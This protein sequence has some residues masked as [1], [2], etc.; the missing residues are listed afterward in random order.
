MV[1]SH[2]P[3]TVETW[4]ATQA[5]ALTGNRTGNPLIHRLALIPLNRTSQ[6]SSGVFELSISLKHLALQFKS[7]TTF[8]AF[9][10]VLFPC[11]LSSNYCSSENSTFPRGERNSSSCLGAFCHADPSVF[12]CLPCLRKAGA[13]VFF[14]FIP[15]MCHCTQCNAGHGSPRVNSQSHLNQIFECGPCIT[16]K[17]LVSVNDFISLTHSKYST[18]SPY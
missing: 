7:Q 12:L 11:L 5:C 6:G 9:S 3:P 16:C 4:P 17:L 2:A 15:P 18:N 8:P 1:A 10:L 13:L 14:I